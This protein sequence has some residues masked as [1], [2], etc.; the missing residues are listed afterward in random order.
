MRKLLFIIP[1]ILLYSCTEN[2]IE[3]IN[4]TKKDI[5]VLINGSQTDW[6]IS[7]EINP[8][9]LKV[10]CINGKNEVVFQTDTDTISF[11]VSENDTVR[12]KIILNSTDTAYTEI[13]GIKD[14]PAK[15]TDEE[16]LYWLSQIWSEI[17]YNFVNIDQLTFDLDSLYKTLIPEVLSSA[18][19]YDY[20]QILSK[21]TAS[22]NIQS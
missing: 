2:Q 9:R 16:K 11:T 10:Y 14:L 19:D 1:F 22:L 20:Y 17:K 13:V 5:K 8:D 18:D 3:S 4:S 15:I 21:F 12:F 6:R 7:P